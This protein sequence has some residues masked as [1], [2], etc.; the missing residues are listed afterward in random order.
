M[1]KEEIK[2]K[3]FS[4]K[5][6]DRRKAA[7]EIGK[8]KLEDLAD[9]LLTAYLEEKKDKRTWETQVEMILALGI[10]NCK[11][12]LPHIEKIVQAN[13]PHDMITY[14][15]AQTYVRLK[16][17]SLNDAKPVI[18]LL[19][20]GGLSLVDG[21][22]NPLAYDKM[23]PP[24]DEIIELLNLCWDLHKHRDRI[25]E[26]YGYTDP[27]YGIA[28][29]CAGWDKN[30]VA[31]FLAHCLATGDKETSLQNVVK[32]SLKGKYAKLV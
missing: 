27:R 13:N 7:K 10:I 8:Q 30:L 9:D 12:V 14:A 6:S 20:F 1:T 2:E 29:A 15:A 17:A 16:R 18:E 24:K 23:V 21:A 19:K 28:A 25:G 3:L 4:S 5:S 22:L 11:Q 26:E 32:S 31:D